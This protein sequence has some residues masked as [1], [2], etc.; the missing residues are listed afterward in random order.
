MFGLPTFNVLWSWVGYLTNSPP[1][2][3]TLPNSPS[4]SNVFNGSSHRLPSTTTATTLTITFTWPTLSSGSH[5]RWQL[6]QPTPTTT[7]AQATP[8]TFSDFHLCRPTRTTKSEFWQPPLM[9][10]LATN[11]DDYL[12]TSNFDYHLHVVNSKLQQPPPMTT[13]V[14]TTLD[15]Q[16]HWQP[17][18]TT[19]VTPCVRKFS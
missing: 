8:A 19:N 1:L 4:L 13:L 18:L 6:P 12:C 15:D 7:F 16:L 14:K 9:T 3:Q 17:P 10:T 11:S 2:T 5:P